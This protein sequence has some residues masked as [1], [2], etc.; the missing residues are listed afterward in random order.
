M[1]T[2]MAQ[3]PATA[4]APSPIDRLG[5]CKEHCAVFGLQW[6]DEGKGK[7]VDLLAERYDLIV[8]YNGG[9]NAG[10]SVQVGSERY[11][12]HLIP[13]G[14]L[15]PRKLNVVGNGVVLDPAKIL[16]EIAGLRKRGVAIG[17]NLRISDRAHV[18]MPYHK[19]MDALLEQ[20]VAGARGDANKIGTTGRGIGPCY[21]DKALRST[22]IRVG[23]LLHEAS[24]RDRLTHIVTVKNAVLAALAAQCGQAFEPLD[25]GA[26]AHEYLGYARELAPHV[27]DTTHLLHRAMNDGRKL[28][29]EGANATMLDIDHGT[30]P[31]VTSSNCSSLGVHTGAGVPGHKVTQV[32]GVMKAYQ[33]RV[34][35]GPMPT[36]LHDATGQRI[37]E[38]G[39]EYGTTTGRPRRCGWLDLVALRY[40]GMVSGA[41]A[42]CVMLLDVLAGLPSIKL[43]TGYSVNGHRL[44]GFP[45][46]ATVLAQAQP[47]YEELP[48]FAESISDC[49]SFADLPDAAR[50]YIERIERAVGVPVRV[51]SVGPRRD[52]TIVR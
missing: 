11:A 18:V 47:I 43:C 34:G 45:A 2:T 19:L 26:I 22:A 52:Q 9:A 42:V 24:F 20:A 25:A 15:N 36:E 14:I 4:A 10:H 21:A 1:A 37:R 51:V 13:S 31:F 29:F 7:I 5:L 39:R 35:G 28:L 46:D 3:S 38:V 12:L 30:Y 27:C 16:D 6:G 50:A 48:G 17:D 44:E 8:R 23:E 49:R 32:L 40:S 33:T 41:T